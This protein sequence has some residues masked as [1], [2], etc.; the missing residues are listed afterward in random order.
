MEIAITIATQ[1]TLTCAAVFILKAHFQKRIDKQLKEKQ[2][3]LD[4]ELEKSKGGQQ[5]PKPH[6]PIAV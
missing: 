6:H 1:L 2:H 5:N 3:Q 4:V